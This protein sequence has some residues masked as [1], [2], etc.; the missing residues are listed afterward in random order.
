[1]SYFR[2]LSSWATLHTENTE[3]MLSMR[4]INWMSINIKIAW[5][6]H[7]NISWFISLFNQFLYHHGWCVNFTFFCVVSHP[8]DSRQFKHNFLYTCIERASQSLLRCLI[9]SDSKHPSIIPRV[10]LYLF[11]LDTFTPTFSLPHLKFW[12]IWLIFSCKFWKFISL[13]LTSRCFSPPSVF[14]F[15]VVFPKL[16]TN[17]NFE[18]K[19]PPSGGVLWVKWFFV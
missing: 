8:I 19:C 14:F 7:T 9:K 6:L 10:E 15:V 5:N 11:I 12:I 13:I 4:N 16:K 3:T 2:F 18:F 1:M 17:P